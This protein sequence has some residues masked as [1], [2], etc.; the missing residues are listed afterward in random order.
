V[1]KWLEYNEALRQRGDITIWFIEEA[2]VAWHPAKTGARGRPQED[3]DL[4]IETALVHPPGLSFGF[5]R[6]KAFC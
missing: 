5:C 1:T 4:G 6:N 3:S 2:L